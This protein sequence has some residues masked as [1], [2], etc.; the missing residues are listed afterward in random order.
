LIRNP[1]IRYFLFAPQP[2]LENRTEHHFVISY[3]PDEHEDATT[4]TIDIDGNRLPEQ[5]ALT[6]WTQT[7][8]ARF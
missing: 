4:V 8:Q 6:R 1:T 7:G 3:T 5:V 2:G